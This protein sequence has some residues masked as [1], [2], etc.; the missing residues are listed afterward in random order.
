LRFVEKHKGWDIVKS[1]GLG[2]GIRARMEIEKIDPWQPIAVYTRVPN[3][4]VKKFNSIK[5]ML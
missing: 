5:E 2:R 4:L 3:F 1:E